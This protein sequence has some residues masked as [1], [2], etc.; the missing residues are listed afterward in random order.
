MDIVSLKTFYAV[1]E[2]LNFTKAA[3]MRFMSQ[4][5]LSRQ[6]SLLE[7]EI[8]FKLFNRN[9]KLVS[10]TSAGSSFLKKAKPVLDSYDELTKAV[11]K[12]QSGVI[13]DLR[14][15][16]FENLGFKI[17]AETTARMKKDY[18]LVDLD[19]IHDEIP[20]LVEQLMADN[21]DVLFT[22]KIGMDNNLDLSWKEL[23]PNVLQCIV[24]ENHPFVELDSVG[25][26]DLE[27]EKI[28][29]PP[30]EDSP[31]VVDWLLRAFKNKKITPELVG[32]GKGSKN[33]MLM[34]LSGKGICIMS[35]K[36]KSN[37][38]PGLAFI[39]LRESESQ[40]NIGLVWK[41]DN[42]NPMIPVFAATAEE[43]SDL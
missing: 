35:S 27:G 42:D 41:S 10:L 4:P 1:T 32:Y 33:M 31:D 19:I 16:Y 30:R 3:N 40:F 17:L 2:C 23:C 37:P 18:P 25:I 14:V 43:C 29:M 39:D 38:L 15:G 22:I 5:T 28:I 6:I 24:P 12:M 8:G 36:L 9:N 34:A 20:N 13:G 21:I 11:K 26:E 7:E